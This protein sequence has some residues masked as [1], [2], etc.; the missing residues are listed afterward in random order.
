VPTR[1]V[2]LEALPTVSLPDPALSDDTI[3]APLLRRPECD[4]LPDDFFARLR[5]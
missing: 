5:D 3:A 1:A 4:H 2:S